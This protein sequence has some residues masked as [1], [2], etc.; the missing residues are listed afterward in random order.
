MKRT[1]RGTWLGLAAV[2]LALLACKKKDP[3]PPPPVTAEAPKPAATPSAPEETI[4]DFAGTYVT[5][6][7]KARC[8][9]VKRNV[10]CLYAGKSGSLDCKVVGAK[11]L[12]CDWE[13]PGLSGKAKLTKKDDGRL[14]GT[15]GNG[16]STT[17]GGPWNFK[18]STK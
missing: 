2:L 12:E 13:E 15:W 6:W 17:N 8:T 18:P 14:V 7:G 9:Q 16:A 1:M 10:N 3:P 5:N 11:D 4:E